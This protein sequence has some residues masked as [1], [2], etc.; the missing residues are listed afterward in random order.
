GRRGRGCTAAPAPGGEGPGRLGW[1]IT[2]RRIAAGLK[3]TQQDQFY[4]RLSVILTPGAPKKGKPVR[5]KP[6]PQEAAEMW[7]TLAAMERILPSSKVKLG[8]A[9]LERVDK[10]KDTDFGFWAVGR[11]GARQPLYG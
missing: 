9:L 1:W 7:R 2:G 11:L 8:E 3:R 6:S 4:N 5:A 10:G